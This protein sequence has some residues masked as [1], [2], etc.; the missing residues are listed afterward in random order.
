MKLDVIGFGFELFEVLFVGA[1][2]L[3]GLVGLFGHES[4]IMFKSSDQV[5]WFL[6]FKKA[7][8]K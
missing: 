7:M 2:G 3:F 4:I 8:L 6:I 5:N 1:Q